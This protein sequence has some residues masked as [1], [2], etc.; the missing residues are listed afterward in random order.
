LNFR[1]L[2]TKQEDSNTKNELDEHLLGPGLEEE[3]VEIDKILP[4]DQAWDEEALDIS[5]AE[6]PETA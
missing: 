3:K 5:D 2:D 6:E 4:V 1:L